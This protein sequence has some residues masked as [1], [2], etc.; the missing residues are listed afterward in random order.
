MNWVPIRRLY[1]AKAAHVGLH[2]VEVKHA[3]AIV[4]AACQEARSTVVHIYGCHHL[5]LPCKSCGA[6]F[7]KAA[8]A[9]DLAV[10]VRVHASVNTWAWQHGCTVVMLHEDVQ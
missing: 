1:S 8:H 2:T 4:P 3:Q 6:T 10:N 5:P 7:D 9:A